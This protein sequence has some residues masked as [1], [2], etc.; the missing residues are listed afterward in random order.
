MHIKQ[1]LEAN[2]K[3]QGG[4][5]SSSN[6]YQT[7]VNLFSSIPSSFSMQLILKEIPNIVSSGDILVCISKKYALNINVK[8]VQHS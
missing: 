8:M 7:T 4:Q 6:H 1:I 5:S 3:T 2:N